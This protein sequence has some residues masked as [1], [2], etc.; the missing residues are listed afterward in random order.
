MIYYK[1][2]DKLSELA[3]ELLNFYKYNHEELIKA[4]SYP[5]SDYFL[6]KDETYVLVG[7]PKVNLFNTNVIYVNPFIEDSLYKTDL[8]YKNSLTAVQDTLGI[9]V[10]FDSVPLSE[11]SEMLVN[12]NSKGLDKDNVFFK[13]LYGYP[14]EIVYSNDYVNIKSRVS[15]DLPYPQ[16]SLYD[17]NN[18]MIAIGTQQS[19]KQEDILR[20]SNKVDTLITIDLSTNKRSCARYID[21]SN[22]NIAQYFLSEHGFKD[23]KETSHF[24]YGVTDIN[25]D[26]ILGI[27][28][29]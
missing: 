5:N 24:G 26:L 11:I 20:I 10:L 2:N 19:L 18:H 13:A 7:L 25:L 1:Q 8:D 29:E 12:P 3:A 22:Q 14:V 21:N 4:I 28:G 9:E 6:D 23:F 17:Y 15:V 16:F 27:E